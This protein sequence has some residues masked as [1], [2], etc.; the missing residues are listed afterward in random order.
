MICYE[1]A[2]DEE[3]E[4]LGFSEEEYDILLGPDG[5]QCA[6]TEPEDRTWRRDCWVVVEELNKLNCRIIELENQLSHSEVKS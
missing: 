4:R 2:T 5:F 3:K 1:V 6:L